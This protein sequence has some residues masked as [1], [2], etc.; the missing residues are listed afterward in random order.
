MESPL[1]DPRLPA[2]RRRRLLRAGGVPLLWGRGNPARPTAAVRPGP[3]PFRGPRPHAGH[4]ALVPPGGGDRGPGRGGPS[5]DAQPGSAAAGRGGQH[6]EAMAAAV[7]WA[8]SPLLVRS[9]R[10]P[11]IGARLGNPAPRAPAGLHQ[12]QTDINHQC[13][14]KSPA[15]P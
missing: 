9:G 11:T 5:P 14:V 10:G 12:R 1:R 3:R 13:A 7:L 6:V 15:W 2:G 4:G 8:V